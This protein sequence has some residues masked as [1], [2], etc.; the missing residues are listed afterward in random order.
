[1]NCKSL[2]PTLSRYADHE[3]SDSE[4]AEVERHLGHCSGCAAYLSEMTALNE[5]MLPSAPVEGSPYLWLRIRQRIHE[6]QDRKAPAGLGW[7]RRVLMP[8]AGAAIVAV[9]VFTAGQLGQTVFNGASDS[10]AR[11]AELNRSDYPVYIED[12]P[13]LED[14]YGLNAPVLVEDDTLP[15]LPVE[16]P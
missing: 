6:Q 4:R 12:E 9:A 15:V 8:A 16:E 11:E 7:L 2:R 5:L 1:M 3:L 13:N 14:E 10:M